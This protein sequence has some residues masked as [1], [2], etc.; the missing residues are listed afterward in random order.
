MGV[1]GCE[2]RCL[3]RGVVGGREASPVV[4]WGPHGVGVGGGQGPRS[5][6]EGFANRGV[7]CRQADCGSLFRYRR[8]GGE[9]GS[10]ASGDAEDRL[11]PR[12][13][14][15]SDIRKATLLAVFVVSRAL[16]ARSRNQEQRRRRPRPRGQHS[17]ATTVPPLLGGALPASRGQGAQGNEVAPRMHGREAQGCGKREGP[18]SRR[19]WVNARLRIRANWTTKFVSG[20]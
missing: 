19:H 17:G 15:D 4:S 16:P 5:G 2:K 7:D 8:P 10:G 3:W 20:F 14:R 9:L 6:G 1:G 13:F 11:A 18:L 12:G